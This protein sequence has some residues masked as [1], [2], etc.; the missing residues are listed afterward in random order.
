MSM[1]SMWSIDHTILNILNTAVTTKNIAG[2]VSL[3]TLLY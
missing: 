3:K 2:N 1:D